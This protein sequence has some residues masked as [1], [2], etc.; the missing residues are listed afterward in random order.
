MIDFIIEECL[1][2]SA[3]IL[4]NIKP[5]RKSCYSY[6]MTQEGVPDSYLGFFLRR[7][8]KGMLDRGVVLLG[9]SV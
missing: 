7:Q 1:F 2:N 5:E 8:T 9:C 3:P 6:F 4:M